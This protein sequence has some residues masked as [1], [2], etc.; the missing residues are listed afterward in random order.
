MKKLSWLLVL[1]IQCS[2][3]VKTRDHPLQA[4]LPARTDP[5]CLIIH[6]SYILEYSKKHKQARWVF[7]KLVY[8]SLD[9]YLKRRGSFEEDSL[10]PFSSATLQ[11]YND[12][13]NEGKRY[14]R[15]HLKPAADSKTSRQD[16]QE[17]F[18]LSNIS[19]QNQSFNR[20]IWQQLEDQVRLFS[21]ENQELFII[22]GPCLRDGLP[23]IGENQVSVPEMFFKVVYDLKEPEK[24]AIAFLMPNRN[25]SLPLTDF[26]ISVDSLE[27]VLGID[28]F[29]QLK[30]KLE[31]Q[32]EKESQ[33]EL[34]HFQKK[35]L[36]KSKQ[37]EIS[38]QKSYIIHH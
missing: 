12:K 2:I 8:D 16:M 29:P 5:S 23:V 13:D 31:N 15:G 18:Y 22:T 38:N 21:K 36:R 7:Y 17:S 27:K 1:T 20:G 32:L 35:H 10:I 26:V 34:W 24:K 25:L 3:M 28:F 14:D 37:P 19:P 6:Q 9:P 4:W 30:N 11:D 33:I